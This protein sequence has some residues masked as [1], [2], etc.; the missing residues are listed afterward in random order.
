MD[1]KIEELTIDE[2]FENWLPKI[3]LA[4]YEELEKSI[5]DE[6]CREKIIVCKKGDKKIIV[7]GHNRY[8]ICSEHNKEY[9]ISEKNFQTRD[10]VLD[11]IFTNQFGKRRPTDEQERYIIGRQYNRMKKPPHRPTET[12]AE[13]GGEIRPLKTAEKIAKEFG[14]SITYVKDAGKYAENIDTIKDK[15]G[16]EPTD[17]ILTGK[18]KPSVDSVKKIAELEANDIKEV[19]EK[20]KNEDKK[21]TQVLN[22]MNIKEPI[23]ETIKISKKVEESPPNILKLKYNKWVPTLDDKS[24]DLLITEP[25]VKKEESKKKFVEE[26]IPLTFSKIKDTGS[27][28]IFV[29]PV[30]LTLKFI[31][32]F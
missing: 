28:Y 15:V 8:K 17:K 9:K 5:L 26:W 3:S 29:S 1:S 20:S 30:M 12:Q 21:I 4:K 16:S 6:G 19:I 13:K 11:F 2:E 7:D 18:N 27:A 31:S 22:E 23:S 24:I 10:E 32:I 25:P 14:H